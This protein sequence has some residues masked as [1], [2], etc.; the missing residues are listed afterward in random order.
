MAWH[1]IKEEAEEEELKEEKNKK[2]HRFELKKEFERVQV[3]WTIVDEG[4]KISMVYIK[5]ILNNRRRQL[6][7]KMRLFQTL[8][9]EDC[10]DDYDVARTTKCP[11]YTRRQLGWKMRLF[12][13]LTLEDCSE[14]YDVARTTK[15]TFHTRIQRCKDHI[16]YILHKVQ[17]LWTFVNQGN[18]ISIVCI[19]DILNNRR[20]QLGRKMRLFQTLT[21]EDCTE[22]YNVARTTKC[23]FY[24]RGQLGR[25]MRFFQTLTLEDCTEDYDVA[26]STKCP[27]YTRYKS[28]GPL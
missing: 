24:T 12:Q 20:R 26:R 16:M 4:N 28:S 5:D 3:F 2:H 25:I 10:S 14:D 22:E 7:R 11:F 21:L 6:G 15:C 13:T 27:F 17:V 23:T 18:K 8:T 19:K 9:L 1:D